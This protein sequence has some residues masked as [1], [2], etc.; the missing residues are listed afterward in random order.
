M[1]NALSHFFE[2]KQLFAKIDQ[3]TYGKRGARAAFPALGGNG[4]ESV[5]VHKS[6]T[7]YP[8]WPKTIKS[9][10]N[11]HI[12]SFGRFLLHFHK[13]HLKSDFHHFFCEL[14]N[15]QET[16]HF[17]CIN[18]KF[19]AFN[20]I[21]PRAWCKTFSYLSCNSQIST[22]SEFSQKS[23]FYDFPEN[24]K[25]V[26]IILFRPMLKIIVFPMYLYRF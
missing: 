21:S 16:H 20:E 22:F 9:L 18:K 17:R 1:K 7:F 23:D 15:F 6:P 13:I 14:L 10:C 3:I 19:M 11:T 8:K 26:K 5:L 24:E 2:I 25:H 4:A 12:F